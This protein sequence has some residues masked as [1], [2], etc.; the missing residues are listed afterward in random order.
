MAKQK[1][2]QALREMDCGK[3]TGVLEARLT[4]TL[5]EVMDDGDIF[6]DPIQKVVHEFAPMLVSK[7]TDNLKRVMKNDEG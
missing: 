4:G 7:L 2:E 6:F 1:V 3:I 5:E